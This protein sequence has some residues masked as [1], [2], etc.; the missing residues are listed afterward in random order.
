MSL[1]ILMLFSVG[2]R[3]L[4][5]VEHLVEKCTKQMS[6]RT[7]HTPHEKAVLSNWLNF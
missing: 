2:D 6:E 7:P 4:Q 3:T 5:D 1:L